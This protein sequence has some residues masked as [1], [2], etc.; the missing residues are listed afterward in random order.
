MKLSSW[1]TSARRNEREREQEDE[2]GKGWSGGSVCVC[3]WRGLM[4]KWKKKK[5]GVKAEV[6]T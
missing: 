3:V 4:E 1:V 5:D 2:E 6:L